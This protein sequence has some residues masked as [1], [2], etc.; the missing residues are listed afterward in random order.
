MLSDSDGDDDDIKPSGTA[1][2]AAMRE[3]SLELQSSEEDASDSDESLM[4]S[5]PVFTK[6]LTARTRSSVTVS[7][8]AAPPRA[9]NV[10]SLSTPKSP[11]S[12]ATMHAAQDDDAPIKYPPLLS[13]TRQYEDLAAAQV[14]SCL[15]AMCTQSSTTFVRCDQ[16]RSISSCE[17]LCCSP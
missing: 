11:S 17:T 1:A 5:K 6:K 16:A 4:N 14:H 10:G 13:N 3:R 15:M 7:S 12:H 8:R 9:V 2:A